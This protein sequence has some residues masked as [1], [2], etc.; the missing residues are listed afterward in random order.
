MH[1]HMH[2]FTASECKC[3][4]AHVHMHMCMCSCAHVPMCTC[5]HVY[6]QALAS[7]IGSHGRY[8]AGEAG[9]LTRGA[10]APNLALRN[11]IEVSQ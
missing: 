9:A 7:W 6:I 11:L 2:A 10:L 8:P 5:A 1:M 3:A 4:H